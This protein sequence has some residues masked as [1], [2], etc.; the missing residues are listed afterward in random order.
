M[1]TITITI[2]D[3]VTFVHVITTTDKGEVNTSS[4][5]SKVTR[6][7]YRRNADGKFKR[8]GQ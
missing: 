5:E 8:I 6:W 7:G 1:K 4:P 2:P 3:G